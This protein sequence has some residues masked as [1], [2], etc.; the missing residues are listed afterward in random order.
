MSASAGGFIPG[1]GAGV[2]VLESLDAALA[3]GARIHAEVLGVATNCGGHR[4]GG[5]MTAPN[6]DRRAALHPGGARRR[7]AS[8]R[9]A[10]TR[11]AA[12]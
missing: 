12:T 10:S 4:G 11:S 5:S 2:L 8:S 3:R 6:P 1:C 7:R 9:R